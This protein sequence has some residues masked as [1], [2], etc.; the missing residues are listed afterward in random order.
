VT[1][2]G[3]K[4][5]VTLCRARAQALLAPAEQAPNFEVKTQLVLMANHWHQLADGAEREEER[6]ARPA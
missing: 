5:A 1:P 2:R 6:Q 3:D 4:A